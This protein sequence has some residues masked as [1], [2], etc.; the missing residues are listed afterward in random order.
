[1]SD[2]KN[3]KNLI[4]FRAYG[5]EP[6]KLCVLKSYGDMVDVAREGMEEFLSVKNNFIHKYDKNLFDE[7]SLAHSQNDQELLDLLWSKTE[8]YVPESKG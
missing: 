7:L 8:P 1:M 4:I 2:E 3:D 5:G 6:V